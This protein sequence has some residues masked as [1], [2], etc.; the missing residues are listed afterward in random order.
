VGER[1]R[2]LR[3]LDR[4]ER[5]HTAMLVRGGGEIPRIEVRRRARLSDWLFVC[6]WA[7]WFL[8]CR[9]VDLPSRVGDLA[10]SLLHV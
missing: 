8:L 7:G 5:V 10:R 3:S 4:A 1:G 2:L 9:L 6:L